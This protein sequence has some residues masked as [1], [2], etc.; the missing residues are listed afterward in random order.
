MTTGIGVVEANKEL[1]PTS[2]T[3]EDDKSFENPVVRE[4][5]FDDAAMREIEAKGR[6]KF[7][8]LRQ[9]WSVAIIIWIS[10]L[11]LFNVAITALVGLGYLNYKEYQWFI[12]AVTI[13]T[14][15][16]IVGMGYIAVKFL[17]SKG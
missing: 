6:E 17:F 13:E 11:I 3:P 2:G 12:T 14:F 15:L 5:Y 7:Y 1:T 8:A 4:N 16:Q 10:L 9:E